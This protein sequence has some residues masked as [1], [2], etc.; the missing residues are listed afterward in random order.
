M[1]NYET[2]V[3]SAIGGALP[4]KINQAGSAA[5][6]RLVSLQTSPNRVKT[7]RERTEMRLSNAGVGISLGLDMMYLGKYE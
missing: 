3:E 1:L 5:T 2:W 4:P 7:R 6:Y